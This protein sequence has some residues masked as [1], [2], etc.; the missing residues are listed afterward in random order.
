MK[1]KQKIRSR[2]DD[3]DGRAYPFIARTEEVLR[4]VGKFA[5]DYFLVIGMIVVLVIGVQFSRV[6]LQLAKIPTEYIC[7]VIIF[8]ISGLQLKTDE[9]YAGIKSYRAIIW[10]FLAILLLTPMLGMQITKTIHFATLSDENMTTSR[11]VVYANVSAIG[12]TEF[13]IGLQVFLA[14]PATVAVGIVLVCNVYFA[15]F[16]FAKHY[17]SKFKI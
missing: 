8:F 4:K 12:P 7:L 14:S 10:S 9:V 17:S 16:K 15:S 3:V 2:M 6:G 13:A 1:I 11:S 5:R